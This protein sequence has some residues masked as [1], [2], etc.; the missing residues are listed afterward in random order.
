[1]NIG[2]AYLFVGLPAGLISSI[3]LASKLGIK[4]IVLGPLVGWAAAQGVSHITYN[5]VTVRYIELN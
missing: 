1:M 4:A 2:D 3:F 5:P